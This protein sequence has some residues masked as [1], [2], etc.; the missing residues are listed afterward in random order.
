MTNTD[1]DTLQ[2]E[3]ERLRRSLERIKQR[4]GITD[5]AK[6]DAT[7]MAVLCVLDHFANQLRDKGYHIEDS[8]F[9][10][11][12]WQTAE[13]AVEQHGAQQMIDFL[14]W[15]FLIRPGHKFWHR[16]V[17]G[18]LSTIMQAY[19]EWVDVTRHGADTQRVIYDNLD[20]SN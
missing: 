5:R 18:K 14:T 19:N 2:R 20:I 15:F 9:L 10:K 12:N 4:W 8:R 11:D 3:N 17:M 1:P 16:V 7:R 13:G 6:F